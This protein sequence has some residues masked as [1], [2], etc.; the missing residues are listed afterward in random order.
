MEILMPIVFLEFYERIVQVSFLNSA[1]LAQV[2]ES[3]VH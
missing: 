3:N 1:R 2:I